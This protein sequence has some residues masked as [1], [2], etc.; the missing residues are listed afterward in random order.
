MATLTHT[1]IFG[2]NR[3]HRSR[4][5]HGMTDLQIPPV[6][7]QQFLN[8]LVCPTMARLDRAHRDRSIDAGTQWLFHVGRHVGDLARVVIGPGRMLPPPFSPFALS[9]SAAAIAAAAEILFEATFE[10]GGLVARA[11][12]LVPCAEGWELIEVKS[13]K[14]PDDEPPKAEYIDDVAYTLCVLQLAG[15]SVVKTTL[16]LLSRDYRHGSDDAMF[17]RVDVSDA[18][19]E[20]ATEMAAIAPRLVE[21]VTSP[22]A[23]APNLQLACKQCDYF[24]EECLG[25]GIDDSVLRIPRLSAPKLAELSGISRIREVPE[26]VSFTDTQQRAVDLIRRRGTHRDDSV[27]SKL[28]SISWP[29]F[30]LDF[31]TVMPALPWFEG[32]GVYTVLPNQYSVHVCTNPGQIVDHR[33]YLASFEADW[34]R[35]LVEKL[36]ADLR[37]DGSIIVYSSYEKTQLSAMANRFDDLRRPIEAL[38]SRLFDLEPFFKSGYIDHRFA[39]ASSIKK[40]LPVLVPDLSYA[41]MAVGD[42]SVASGLFCL[43]REGVVPAEEHESRRKDLLDYCRLDTLAMVR[44]HEA[45]TKL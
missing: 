27:L 24:K 34:R 31:E 39:G 13:G 9:E 3:R 8:A 38:L 45:L 23:P 7:K 28:A 36:L 32:D 37:G 2:Y 44:L 42:G 14:M 30:Y 26:S 4:T 18:A 22:S 41:E 21:S 19:R 11:D 12:A 33:D 20:R 17:G 1:Y 16:M 15:V 43:M 29:A 40:V 35:E 25:K 10:A 6:T 5:M